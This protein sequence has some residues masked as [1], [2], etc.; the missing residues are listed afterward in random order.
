MLLGRPYNDKADIWSL[1]CMLTEFFI[2][3]PL[4]PGGNEIEM[5]GLIESK[6]VCHLTTQFSTGAHSCFGKIKLFLSFCLFNFTTLYYVVIHAVLFYFF[7]RRSTFESKF[8]VIC[9]CEFL[10]SSYCN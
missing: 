5:V 2:G 10:P 7:S 6:L 3:T 8:D 1:A 9:P 4:F